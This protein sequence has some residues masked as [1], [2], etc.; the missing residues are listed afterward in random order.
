MPKQQLHYC[1]TCLF[2]LFPNFLTAHEFWLQPIDFQLDNEQI[3]MANVKIGTDLSGDK[4]VYLPDHIQSFDL[5]INDKTKP[6]ESSFAAQPPVNQRVF[7]DSLGILSAT[8]TVKVVNYTEADV[9]LRFLENEGLKGVHAKHQERGL[10]GSGFDEAYRRY[11]KSLIKIG[12]GKG[13][14][15]DLGLRFEWIIENNPYTT[16]KEHIVARLEWQGKALA[17]TQASVFRKADDVVS[18]QL[19][20]TDQAGKIRIPRESG[21]FLINAV[22]MTEPLPETLNIPKAKNS[23]WESHWASIT[24]GSSD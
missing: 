16:D 23:V 8:S 18:R 17:N 21:L 1:L 11:A 12:N 7:G 19:F 2:C 5:T 24:Y 15:Q 9:F 4:H 3:L 20:Q 14:D 13:Q 22:H 10:P 6:I